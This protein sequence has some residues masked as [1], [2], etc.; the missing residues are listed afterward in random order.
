MRQTLPNMKQIGNTYIACVQNNRGSFPE[1]FLQC[2]T[3][4]ML[5]LRANVAWYFSIIVV[6]YISNSIVEVILLGKRL[7]YLNGSIF[8]SAGLAGGS[9]LF[10]TKLIDI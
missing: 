6:Q 7:D 3:S 4:N 10:V 5:H 9:L 2:I 8:L 1:L